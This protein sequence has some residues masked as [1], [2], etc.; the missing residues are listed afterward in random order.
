VLAK[1]GGRCARCGS[2]RNVEAHHLDPI[3]QGGDP[4]DA[5]RGVPLC[6][7]CHRK[8]EAKIKRARREP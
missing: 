4:T 3:R 7:K 2:T 5:S 6:A 8:V 1:T